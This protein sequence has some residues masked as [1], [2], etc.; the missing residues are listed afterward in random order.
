LPNA[1][2]HDGEFLGHII[3]GGFFENS[4][5]ATLQET[6][7][8]ALKHLRALKMNN[9]QEWKPLVIEILNDAE[10]GEADLERTTNSLF[11]ERPGTPLEMRSSDNPDFEFANQLISAVE[12]LYATR[13]ARGV[14]AT[15]MLS[16][17]ALATTTGGTFVQFRL[18][19]NM[20]PSPPLGWLLTPASRK[21]MDDLIVGPSQS[22]DGAYLRCF[23][24]LQQH[25]ATVQHLL[26]E[27]DARVE[28]A[29]RA[30]AN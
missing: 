17:Y 30:N 10:M 8:E 1:R 13:T 16:Q 18:C 3:D 6:I 26:L 20:N 27:E 19:P 24:E 4:G 7:E 14:L 9:G 12:G 28:R 21:A 2:A 15:K 22:R 23:S 11:P 5:A 25:L 29:A